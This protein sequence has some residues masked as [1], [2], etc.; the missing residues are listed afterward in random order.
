MNRKQQGITLF[1]F[2][3]V[4]VVVAYFAFTAIRL[5]PVYTEYYSV[6]ES[7]DTVAKLPSAGNASR[8]DIEK[9]LEKRFDIGYV[10]SVDLQKNLT[11]TKVPEGQSLNVVYEV[12]KPFAYNVDFVAKFDYT[13][14]LRA[15]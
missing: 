8:R 3:M 11:L 1:G 5:F 6:C 2:L 4:L 13:V 12:R 7:M 15:K 10:E 14:I 9:M